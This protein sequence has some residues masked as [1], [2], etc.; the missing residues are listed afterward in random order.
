[1]HFQIERDNLENYKEKEYAG[2]LGYPAFHRA[3]IEFALTPQE[4][5]V[6]DNLVILCTCIFIIIS[7]Y[8]Y[9]VI[10]F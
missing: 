8:Y 4:K 10:F 7:Y 2:I 5:H 1:M 6:K 9:Y 3:A